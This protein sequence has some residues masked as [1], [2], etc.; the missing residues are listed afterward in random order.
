[1]RY[2]VEI[3]IRKVENK[4]D[5]WTEEVPDDIMRRSVSPLYDSINS[6]SEVYTA[7]VNK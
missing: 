6:A 2:R 1:M 3:L 4:A 5:H 7:L